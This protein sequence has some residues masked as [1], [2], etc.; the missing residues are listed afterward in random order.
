M[1]RL[2][3]F[4]LLVVVSVL[5]AAPATE[6]SAQSTTKSV[7]RFTLQTGPETSGVKFHKNVLGKPC[8]TFEAISRAE[9]INADL[10]DHIVAV[11]NQCVQRIKF[12]VCYYN[13]DH[14]VDSETEGLGRTELVLGIYPKMQYFRYTYKEK[15]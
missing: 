11:K 8:L 3:L 15:F 6:V 4:P 13:S 2:E 14:C 10:Y 7:S 5:G 12:S 9:L 1:R